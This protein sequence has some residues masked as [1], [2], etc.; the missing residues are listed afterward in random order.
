MY[1]HLRAPTRLN[2]LTLALST[3]AFCFIL[4]LPLHAQRAGY[5]PPS[6]IRHEQTPMPQ[7]NQEFDVAKAQAENNDRN[8]NHS[9]SASDALKLNRDADELSKLAQSIPSSVDQTTKGVLPQDLDQ[10][11][12]RIEKLARQLRSHISH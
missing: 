4:I 7:H 9:L 12:K 1:R 8:T 10:R 2:T 3:F 6:T 5:T 11:L